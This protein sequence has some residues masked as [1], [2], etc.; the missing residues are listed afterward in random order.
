MPRPPRSAPRSPRSRRTASPRPRW[1]APRAGLGGLRALALRGGAAIADALAT[2]E[3]YG[4]P[5]MTYRQLPAALAR[6][7]APDVARAARRFIDPK[8]ETIAVVRPEAQATST[9]ARAAR[10]DRQGRAS[11]RAV[12]AAPAR[13][14]WN[15]FC[16]RCGAPV[17]NAFIGTIVGELSDPSVA[18]GSAG[19]VPHRAHDDA[20]RSGNQGPPAGAG[21]VRPC[22]FERE[23]ESAAG[24]TTPNIITTTSAAPATGRSSG[25]GVPGRDLARRGNRRRSNARRARAGDRASN[26]ARA[27]PRARGRASFTADAGAGEHHAGRAR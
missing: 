10:M 18:S 7:T 6:V 16:A 8:R 24:S 22:R 12:Q 19:W 5:L 21:R 3:A 14:S 11:A 2:D 17:T 1:S 4:L 25:D 20:P 26:P 27:R 9:V 13:S 23:A 15:S